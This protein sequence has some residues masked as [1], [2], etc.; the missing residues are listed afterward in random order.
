MCTPTPLTPDIPAAGVEA[1]I[2]TTITRLNS[3][4]AIISQIRE[5]LDWAS[6]ARGGPSS[7][8]RNKQFAP[9]ADAHIISA[10]RLAIRHN[11]RVYGAATLVQA[12][13]GVVTLAGTVSD[14]RARQEAEHDARHVEG[15]HE[16]H[17]LLKI[18][19]DYIMTAAETCPAIITGLIPYLPDSPCNAGS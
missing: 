10:V 14:L 7:E 3:D 19:P 18:R 2:A 11:P 4:E 5:L 15:V 1:D 13:G 8:R 17:N 16:V 9:H 6:S 12:L